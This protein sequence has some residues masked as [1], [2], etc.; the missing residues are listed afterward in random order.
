MAVCG[1]PLCRGGVQGRQIIGRRAAQLE[2]QQIAE[3]LVVAVGRALW[4]DCGHERAGP[5]EVGEDAPGVC[6]AG[7]PI[8]Q[9]PGDL[10]QDRCA[11]QQVSH[12]RG[13]ALED[14]GEQVLGDRAV[15]A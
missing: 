6:A 9:P 12:L 2:R 5:L 15:A 13:L 10:L 4:V 14:L 3:E 1:E 8:G 7:E 11:K